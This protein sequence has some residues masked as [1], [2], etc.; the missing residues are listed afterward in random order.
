MTPI[1]TSLRA[2]LLA[3]ALGLAGC[4]SFVLKAP[5]DFVALDE[6]RGEFALRTT[7]AEGVVLAV[8]EVENDRHGTLAFWRKAIENRVRA[9]NG[10]ALLNEDEVHASTGEAGRRLSFGRDEANQAF[11]YELTVFVTPETFL[12]DGHVFVVEAGGKKVDFD[13]TAD[14]IR[15]AVAGIELKD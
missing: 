14:K 10:Y 4:Q 3:L 12:S 11:A 13:A 6:G 1:T 2:S 15:A 5:E 7:N 9:V 8:R